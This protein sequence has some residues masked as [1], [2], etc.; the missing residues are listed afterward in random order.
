MKVLNLLSLL[1]IVFS[2]QAYTN[3]KNSLLNEYIS[4][5][6]L[7]QFGYDY[8]KNEADTSILRDSWITPI[9][10]NYTH[11][12]SNPFGS[13][14]TAKT[15]AIKMD[16]PIF[17]SGGIYYGI[18]FAQAVK[19]YSDYSIDV[20][21]RK[22]IKDTISILMQT[23][24]KDLQIKKQKLQIENSKINLKIKQE[25]YLSGRLDV[26][27]LDSAV[28]ERNTVI[29]VLYDI[30]T[31]KQSL[32]SR[33]S[34]LS[35]LDYKVA[36]VPSL[37]LLNK[38][39]F[40]QYNI[41]LKMLNS[42]IQRDKFAQGIRVAKYLPQLS[43]TAGYKWTKSDSLFQFGSQERDYHEY[44]FKVSMP[45]NINTFRDIESA[46]VDYLK[47]EVFA[48]DKKIELIALFEQVLINIK[49]LEKKK[50]LSFENEEIYSKLL[51]DTEKL[52]KAGYKTKYDV[53]TLQNSL[54]IS[55][56]TSKVYEIDEQ[57]ELLTLYEMYVNENQ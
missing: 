40:L 29:Q 52:F 31:A 28:I 38:E 48:K 14:Q 4:K 1:L 24:Q 18:K 42:Q 30:Q 6:K 53:Q 8:Q 11:T 46:K 10:L 15:A 51:H 39:E 25:E 3:E 44:G 49:N 23:K 21:K 7:E 13:D 17:Q 56:Y 12:K 57:L 5:N 36:K 19:K 41:V 16:Q 47:S 37:E 20:A 54:E 27:F 50:L 22:L 43:F 2:T 26:G 35:D 33:F 34:A 55:K 9:N 32:V 45:L